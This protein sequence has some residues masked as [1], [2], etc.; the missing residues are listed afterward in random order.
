[1]TT[2]SALCSENDQGCFDLFLHTLGKPLYGGY[3]LKA[4]II[5]PLFLLFS[6]RLA[7]RVWAWMSVVVIPLAFYNVLVHAPIYGDYYNKLGMSNFW[8]M[9]YFALSLAIA[10]GVPLIEYAVRRLR[11]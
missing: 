9:A 7:F 1:V 6:T 8:G 3:L 2:K 5:A 4:I 11:A 10:V